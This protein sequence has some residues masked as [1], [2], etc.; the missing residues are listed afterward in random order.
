[1]FNEDWLTHIGGAKVY[2]D[3]TEFFRELTNMYPDLKFGVSDCWTID[4]ERPLP[5]IKELKERYPGIAFI[6]PHAHYP[7]RTW[8]APKKMYTAFDP[9]IGSD[10]K[11]HVTEFG[12]FPG[13]IEG[14]YRTGTWDDRSLAEYFVQVYVVCFSHPA[15]ET[16]NHWG[17]GPEDISRF[18]TNLIINEDY[19][20][21]PPYEAIRSL[22]KDKLTT[23]LR[24]KTD[25]D[26]RIVFRGFHGRYK[27]TITSAAGR[28][29]S[30]DF[31][32][33]AKTNRFTF[34]VNKAMEIVEQ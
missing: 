32:M 33:N 28:K 5:D 25:V 15:V 7:R 3:Q 26:G 31:S 17:I 18:K 27:M 21:R 8:I 4:G 22:L 30:A 12:L 19:T 13:D 10:V 24:A 29:A 20:P 11:I 2:F 1:V 6:A 14:N 23:K 34:G 16:F 9:Y